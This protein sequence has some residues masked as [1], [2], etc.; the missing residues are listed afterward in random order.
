MTHLPLRHLAL[1]IMVMGFWGTNFVAVRFGLDVVPPALLSSLRFLLVSLPL[2]FFLPRPRVPLR[3]LALYALLAFTL[4]FTLLFAAMHVGMPTGLASLVIQSQVFFTLL[5]TMLLEG[6]RPLANQLFGTALGGIGIGV[7]ALGLYAEVPLLALLLVLAAALSWSGSNLVVRHMGGVNPVAMIV[8]SSGLACIPLI[9]ISLA[10][11][12]LGAW[13]TAWEA[14]STGNPKL[15]GALAYNVLGAS[16]IGYGAWAF[17]LKHYPA[18]R[19]APFTLLVP[20]FGILTASIVLGERIDSLTWI[21][22]ALVFA[23][24]ALT[25][26]RRRG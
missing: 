26:W 13:Q 17:L 2:V 4:Q 25:Q 24:L 9:P 14:L 10:M 15:W 7:V 16:L 21:G 20:V 6:E 5:L 8:W 19:V 22:A 18:S 23:G 12:G 11:E 1:T 3:L